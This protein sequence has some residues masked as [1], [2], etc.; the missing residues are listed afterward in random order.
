MKQLEHKRFDE[1]YAIMDQAFPDVEMRTY[2]EQKRLLKDPSYTIYIEED[3]TAQICAFLGV[4]ELEDI[5]F[6]EHLA[7]ASTMRGSGI[8]RVFLQSFL[9]AMKKPMVLEV[10][11]PESD[12]AKRRIGFYQRLGF[13][14]HEQFYLQPP[15][16]SDAPY[17]PLYLMSYP[18]SLDE[19]GFCYIRDALY[20]QVYKLHRLSWHKG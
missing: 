9:Q 14:L 11:H 4:W 18:A 8:G 7:V 3:E 10:E 12:I 5:I 20:Q 13:H 16:R 2:E 19:A 17:Y 6:I 15:L 1:V